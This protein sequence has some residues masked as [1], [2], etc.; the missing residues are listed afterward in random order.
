MSVSGNVVTAAVTSC[1][2]EASSE[3]EADL[4]GLGGG[5]GGLVTPGGSGSVDVSSCVTALMYTVLALS[6]V[7]LPVLLF[8][9][10]TSSV[11]G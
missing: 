6:D 8:R 2:G 10:L 5:G 1:F 7:L 11:G 9:L 3:D 4:D